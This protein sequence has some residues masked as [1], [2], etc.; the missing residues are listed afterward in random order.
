MWP[1]MLL[2]TW[3]ASIVSV[4]TT[5]PSP[6]GTPVPDSAVESSVATFKCNRI[7]DFKFLPVGLPEI[8][9]VESVPSLACRPAAGTIVIVSQA[10]FDKSFAI[11]I[12]SVLI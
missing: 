6:L 11:S 12:E 2:S 10:L 7:S 1:G 5:P 9:D 3:V 4:E 8:S